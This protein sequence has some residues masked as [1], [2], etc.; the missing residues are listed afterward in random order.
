ML[1]EIGH[2]WKYWKKSVRII[3][4]KANKPDSTKPKVYRVIL[5]FNCLS[6]ILEKVMALRLVYLAN[7]KSLLNNIQIGGRK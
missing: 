3:L 1:F 5:L 4:L 7:I 2:H 6:K